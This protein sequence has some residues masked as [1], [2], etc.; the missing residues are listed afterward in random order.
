MA[1]ARE[2]PDWEWEFYKDNI[3]IWYLKEDKTREEVM[4]RMKEDYGFQARYHWPLPSLR[5]I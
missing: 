2:I 3:G 4:E 5:S 1:S